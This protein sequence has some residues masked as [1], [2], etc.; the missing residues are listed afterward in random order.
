MG[1]SNAAE[2]VS[3]VNDTTRDAVLAAIADGLSNNLSLADIADNIAE[4]GASRS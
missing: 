1:Y 4:L 3:Q 2:L